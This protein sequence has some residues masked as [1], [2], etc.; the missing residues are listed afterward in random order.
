MKKE[1]LVFTHTERRCEQM[2]EYFEGPHGEFLKLETAAP[3]GTSSFG[4]SRGDK[5]ERGWFLRWEM[6]N[7]RPSRKQVAPAIASFYESVSVLDN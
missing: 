7:V 6:G 3:P 4:G 1:L 2:R 5:R